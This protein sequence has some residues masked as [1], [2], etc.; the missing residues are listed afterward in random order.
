M[1]QTPPWHS[2]RQRDGKVY[3]DDDQCPVAKEIDQK[4]RR[5]GHRCR[6]RCRACA[7]LRDP[8][9]HSARHAKLMPL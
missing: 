1:A 4:Y 2:I 3:H 8:A 6:Q 9:L 7:K 5:T